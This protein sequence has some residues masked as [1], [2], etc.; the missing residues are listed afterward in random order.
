MRP[1]RRLRAGE[2]LH[3]AGGRAVLSIGGRTAAGDTFR[4]ELLGAGEPLDEV[5][6]LGEMPLPPYIRTRLDRPGRYQTVYAADPGLGRRP[7]RWAPLHAG[8]ARAARRAGAEVHGGARRRPRHVPA[9]HRARPARAPRCTASATSFRRRRGRRAAPPR[10][11]VAVGTTTVRALETAAATGRLA[12]R[13]ELFIHRGFDCSG[14]RR[15][16]DQLPPAAHDAADDDRRLRRRTL[17]RAVRDGARRAVPLP[18]VRRRDAPRPARR[19]LADAVGS[20]R[21]RAPGDD[22]R[23]RP[24]TG[25]PAPASATTAGARYT[26]PLF[27]P[28][29]TRGAIK[30]LSAADYDRARRA[31]RA[32]QHVPPDAAARGRRRRP[33]RWP[34]PVRRLGRAD[35]HRFGRLPGVLARA[36]RSTTTGS[37]SERLRRSV[38]RFTPESAVAVQELLGA[39]IQMV[40]DVCPPLPSPPEVIGLAVERTAAWARAGPRRPPREDQSLFGIVQ[41]GID[42]ALRA[43][44]ARRTVELGFDGYGIGGLSVGETARRCCPR[45]RRPRRAAGRPP[46]LPDG[47]RRPG[48]ARRGGRRSASTSS[49]A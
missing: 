49:T 5:D 22:R 18:V 2:T 9:G 41:G 24:P 36:R 43:E 7:D 1:A 23:S 38:H 45:S 16:A 26:T 21:S 42:E 4:V 28:V 27:M 32:R 37:R 48:V 10:R 31:D 25:R 19:R 33:L 3:A 8:A 6:E 35:P 47:C 39:D 11:V 40:L 17:A 12:G 44:S 30:Y 15:A 14:R 20:R 46:A 13:T 29:G 34:R